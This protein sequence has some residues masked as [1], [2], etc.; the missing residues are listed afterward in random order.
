MLE[1]SVS[2]TEAPRSLYVDPYVITAGLLPKIV[3]TGRLVSVSGVVVAVSGVVVA[4]ESQ[5]PASETMAPLCIFIQYGEFV[6][7][8]YIVMPA[9]FVLEP[10]VRVSAK[11][12]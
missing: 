3:I 7:S 9:G 2:V 8:S 12:F 10:T 5:V 6:T 4:R 1:A 11:T